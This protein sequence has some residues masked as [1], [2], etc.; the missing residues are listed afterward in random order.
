MELTLA[1]LKQ[2]MP[3]SKYAAGYLPFLIKW[4]H[5]YGI[6][7]T[8]ERMAHFLA[9]IAHESNQLNTVVENLN[10][11]AEGLLKTFKKYFTP[12]QAA[13]YARQPEKIANRVYANRMGNGPEASGDGWKNR[14]MGLIQIT[15]ADNRK[16]MARDWNVL[17][18]DLSTP[19]NAVRSA[20]WF[21]WTNILNKKVDA[22]ATVQDVTK[23]VNGGTNGL[24]EREAYYN[25]AV[26]ALKED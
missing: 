2:T 18:V 15:G 16:A 14:G 7:K 13:K 25:V 22:G 17:S 5:W 6:D 21:W 1:Q 12:E 26:K 19:D 24:A 23:V 4:M 11:S 20:C 9:Q 10:Y 8:T 3:A